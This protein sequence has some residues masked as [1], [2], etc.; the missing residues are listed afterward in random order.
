MKKQLRANFEREQS[1]AGGSVA[2]QIDYDDYYR[3]QLALVKLE[4]DD[5]VWRKFSLLSKP[6]FQN[7]TESQLRE[8]S[9]KLWSS[10]LEL[11]AHLEKAHIELAC[12]KENVDSRV[13]M[14]IRDK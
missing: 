2:G 14:Y 13:N 11:L 3:R 9:N 6:E 5:P 1:K 8:E 10:K 4:G 7:M 12:L